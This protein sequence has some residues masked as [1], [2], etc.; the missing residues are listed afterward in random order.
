MEEKLAGISELL[1]LLQTSNHI[2]LLENP[3]TQACVGNPYGF[4]LSYPS[5]C[6]EAFGPGEMYDGC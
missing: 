2:I 6:Y 1:L 3:S 4:S 5:T